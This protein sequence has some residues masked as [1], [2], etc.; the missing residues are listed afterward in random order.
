M[1]VEKNEEIMYQKRYIFSNASAAC[2]ITYQPFIIDSISVD[3]DIKYIDITVRLIVGSKIYTEFY[4]TPN[5]RILNLNKHTVFIDSRQNFS[6]EISP[7]EF[8]SNSKIYV[9]LTGRLIRPVS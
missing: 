6:V 4:P 2:D 5:N 1:N 7:N 8:N 3:F 9:L